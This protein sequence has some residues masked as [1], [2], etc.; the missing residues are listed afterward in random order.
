MLNLSHDKKMKRVSVLYLLCPEKASA[1]SIHTASLYQYFNQAVECIKIFKKSG[2]L[3]LRRTRIPKGC[4]N[5]GGG[6]E[7]GEVDWSV[8]FTDHDS[9]NTYYSVSLLCHVIPSIVRKN[10]VRVIFPIIKK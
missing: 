5:G 6:G 8:L 7:K 10:Q 2:R 3:L 9:S 4:S 1:Y